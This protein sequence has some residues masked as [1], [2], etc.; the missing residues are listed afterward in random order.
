MGKRKRSKSP[1][2][3]EVVGDSYCELFFY[4]RVL[5]RRRRLGICKNAKCDKKAHD[6]IVMEESWILNN[7]NTYI[8][9][10][11]TISSV[12]GQNYMEG[13]THFLK[14]HKEASSIDIRMI[15]NC[16]TDLEVAASPAID[17][18]IPVECYITIL[19]FM[20]NGIQRFL[21]FF[22]SD[23]EQGLIPDLKSAIAFER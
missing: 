5:I 17:L 11:L 23:I 6:T 21:H 10:M 13:A 12:T 18:Q 15:Y 4:H 3:K 9:K 2:R 8:E 20:K 16:F 14:G 7:V 22:S 19:S 1:S